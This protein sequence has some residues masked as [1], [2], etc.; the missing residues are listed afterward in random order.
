MEDQ[1]LRKKKIDEMYEEEEYQKLKSRAEFEK[2]QTR[3]Q[4]EPTILDEAIK[5]GTQVCIDS[6]L[7]LLIPTESSKVITSYAS[8]MNWI[9]NEQTSNQSI[10]NSSLFTMEEEAVKECKPKLSLGR[11]ILKYISN[12]I[13]IKGKKPHKKC[14]DRGQN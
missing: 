14:N 8:P 12:L 3:R 5:A 7:D 4:Q 2:Q 6:F 10:F 11:R 9:V 1:S 13:Q